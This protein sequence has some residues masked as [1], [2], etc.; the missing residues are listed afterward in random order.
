MGSEQGEESGGGG[1]GRRSDR[2]NKHHYSHLRKVAPYEE[3]HG[4][5]HFNA[6]PYPFIPLCNQFRFLR[7]G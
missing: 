2:K 1:G 3:N 6:N 5:I 4:L 7:T